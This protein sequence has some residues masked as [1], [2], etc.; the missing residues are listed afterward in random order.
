ML[1]TRDLAGDLYINTWSECPSHAPELELC[2][3]QVQ[4]ICIY[5]KAQEP[6]QNLE[7][8]VISRFQK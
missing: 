6:H 8:H 1:L 4:E 7:V 3:A 2:S 5:Y